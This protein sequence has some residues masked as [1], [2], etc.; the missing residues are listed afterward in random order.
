MP[1]AFENVE[2]GFSIA[3]VFQHRSTIFLSRVEI[4]G[5]HHFAASIPEDPTDRQRFTPS[6]AIL[7]GAVFFPT[8][9][10]DVVCARSLL[11]VHDVATG[12]VAVHTSE[13]IVKHGKRAAVL[14]GVTMRMLPRKVAV[15]AGRRWSRSPDRWG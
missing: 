8:L 1:I 7:F 15:G 4:P 12:Y 6:D 5:S 14:M 11:V 13:E 9:L 2:V 10:V 3:S